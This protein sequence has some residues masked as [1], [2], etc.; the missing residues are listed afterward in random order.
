MLTGVG[1]DLNGGRHR[2]GEVE[3]AGGRR[4]S[5]RVLGVWGSW[6]WMWMWIWMW[7]FVI[8]KLPTRLELNGEFHHQPEK[9]MLNWTCK[10]GKNK[11]K[12][13][14]VYVI[15]CFYPC[16]NCNVAIVVL[17]QFWSFKCWRS[18]WNNRDCS[19]IFEFKLLEARN[20]VMM[21]LWGGDWTTR[22]RPTNMCVCVF[23]IKDKL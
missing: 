1:G 17:C 12:I 9:R 13:M 3:D 21:K 20:V 4:R 7:H 6:M 2:H 8:F 15:C 10:Y 18:L 23:V 11:H 16:R 22:D 14:H 19:E 5:R